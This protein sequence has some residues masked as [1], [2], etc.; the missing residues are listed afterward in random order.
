MTPAST[1]LMALLV[2]QAPPGRSSFSV[3]PVAECAGKSECEGAKWSSFYQTWVRQESAETATKRYAVIAEAIAIETTAALCR[4]ALGAKVVGCT[5]Q[6]GAKLWSWWGLVLTTAAVAI[7]ESGLREDVQVGRGAAKKPSDDGGRGRGPGLERCLTQIHPTVRNDD[8]LLGTSLEANR[9]CFRQAI[10]MLVH[11]RRYCAWKSPK[12][13]P[14]FAAVSLYGTGVSCTA[15]NFGKTKKRVDL[16]V[17][18]MGQK[19]AKQRSER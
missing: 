8:A 15:P 4:D 19:Q 3:E 6:Q 10:G 14:V 2:T 9:E 11:A 13:D 17:K 7:Q 18:L 5:P 1:I 16:A 12:T